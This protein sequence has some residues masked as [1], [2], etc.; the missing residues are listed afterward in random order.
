MKNKRTYTSKLSE[1][2]IKMYWYYQKLIK[3]FKELNGKSAFENI[4]PNYFYQQVAF[5]FGKDWKTVRVTIRE[6]NQN[7]P[8]NMDKFI[9]VEIDPNEL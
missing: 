9:V 6:L 3:D 1:N 8:K 5:S 4:S 2:N 7:P